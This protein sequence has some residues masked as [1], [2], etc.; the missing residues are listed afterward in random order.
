MEKEVDR[1]KRE[2]LVTEFFLPASAIDET[3]ERV[4]VGLR[5]LWRP[6][7]KPCCELHDSLY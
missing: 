2:R 6:K 4:F 5:E 3:F 1:I 7:R